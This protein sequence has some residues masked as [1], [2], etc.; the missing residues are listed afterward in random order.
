[1]RVCINMNKIREHMI[2]MIDMMMTMEMSMQTMGM[3]ILSV[4]EL[5]EARVLHYRRRNL[6]RPRNQL[7]PPRKSRL[8]EW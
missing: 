5:V 4:G 7:I 2:M 8:M 6:R 1:M 3:K